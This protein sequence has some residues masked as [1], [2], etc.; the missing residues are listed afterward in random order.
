[1]DRVLSLRVA[2]DLDVHLLSADDPEYVQVLDA[3]AARIAP[4]L[5]AD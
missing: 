3:L 4:G 1:L 5:S 2:D